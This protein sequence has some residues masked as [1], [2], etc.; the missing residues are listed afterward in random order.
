[1]RLKK[2]MIINLIQLYNLPIIW[3]IFTILFWYMAWHEWRKSGK[4]LQALDA[5]S[6]LKGGQVNI[7]GVN[8]AEMLEKFK[9]EL[10][11]SNRESHTIAATSYL[12][13]GLAALASFIISLL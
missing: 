2:V 7:L 8:F 5:I 10:N 11:K 1:M 13:A 9:D 12:L 4:K 3:S 6:P